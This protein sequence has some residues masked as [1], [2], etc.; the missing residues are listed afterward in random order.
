M[1][2]FASLI[3][4]ITCLLTGMTFA[5][6]SADRIGSYEMSIDRLHGFEES[7]LGYTSSITELD[8]RVVREILRTGEDETSHKFNLYLWDLLTD[9]KDQ[10]IPL[11]MCEYIFVDYY[12]SSPD[13][14]PAL[15]GKRMY[16]IQGRL[17]PEG[18]LGN[19]LE[20][21]WGTKLYSDGITANRWSTLTI[22]VLADPTITTL[23]SRLEDT[24]HYLHQM[25]LFPL[26]SD[27]GKNDALYISDIRFMSYH[28]DNIDALSERTLGFYAEAGAQS[29]YYT[30]RAKDADTVVLPSP[31]ISKLPE[32]TTFHY[33]QDQSGAKYLPGEEYSVFLGEDVRFVPVTSYNFDFSGISD[34]Y[35]NGYD[36]G[37]FRPGDNITRAEAAKII[38]SLVNPKNTDNGKVS[39][40]DVPEDAWYYNHVA[41]LERLSA[42]EFFGDR[43]DPQKKITR[44]ELVRIIYAV[45][46]RERAAA[47]KLF[48][49][50]DVGFDND[51]FEAVM[52]ACSN[53]I[54]TG[55][56]DKTF[57][58]NNPITRAETVT[59]INRF[60][61]RVPADGAES[62]F[63]DSE[64]HWASAQI[65]AAAS[66]MADGTWTRSAGSGEF[67]LAGKSSTEYINALYESAASLSPDAVRRGID[68]V[69]EQM[70]KDILSSPNTDL[71]GIKNVYYVSP[72]GNDENNG[73]S[74]ETAWK[75]LAKVNSVN[76]G[77]KSAILF[78]RGG[79]WRGQIK[80]KSN[81]TYGAY[82]EGE[83]PV[84]SGSLKNYANASLCT[85][86]DVP[87]VYKCTDT[88]NNVG[89]I[90]F[91]HDKYAHGNY[92]GLYG[93]NRI[94]S[95]N[96]K[97]YKGLCED[98]EFFSTDRELYL[99]CEGGNP[100]RRFSSIEIGTRAD[101]IDGA[102]YNCTVDNLSIKH[103]GA[104]GVG[105]GSSKN[106]TVKNCEFSW[107]GGSLLGD[108]GTTTTQ[109]GNA[110]EIY[111]DCDGYYV[112]DNWMY[113]IY[114]TAVTHQFAMR[115][116]SEC[117]M[118]D[119]EYRGNLMEYVHWG[120]EFYISESTND[121]RVMKDYI[122][123]H[124]VLREGGYGWGSIVTDRQGIARLYSCSTLYADNSNLRCEYNVIDRCAG[125]LID[126]F[127]DSSE[128][129]DSNIYVQN[130]DKKLGILK[131]EKCGT[132]RD[133]AIRIAE[134][135]GDKNA[136]VIFL[137]SK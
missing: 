21:A 98:L 2:K 135:L 50:S 133:A 120:I 48:Y 5:A 49:L 79:Y 83:K 85:A 93:K 107:L 45:G 90:V 67:V 3:L 36:D 20:F 15:E 70:K 23:V 130:E 35:I 97:D 99:Y 121:R 16:W 134:N 104:H 43:F 52:Y 47:E 14:A 96:I 125:Y 68:T 7:T 61:G 118:K 22:P 26:E 115:D 113:Q 64:K 4:C 41:T 56:E 27:M 95:V 76:V 63:D 9:N 75:T 33:W 30:M 53:G 80:A 89:V 127:T 69:S 78:E 1:K 124:N 42:L 60:I 112:Y 74:P 84:I 105:F 92:D 38:A 28:P 17:A 103:T 77:F 57:R 128:V 110:V 34:A 129:F 6:S 40:S 137:P 82:G 114:D 37:S 39:F 81:V 109:Y 59:V 65:T 108:F 132:S 71:S 31:D 13:A 62:R 11:D 91:D 46:K 25:K 19:V 94:L 88:L 58:P 12:Y 51:C 102:P 73:K 32:N 29:P 136:I 86:T 18:A 119:I 72:N 44:G 101:V 111:G 126:V 100:G 117:T 66:A 24:R 55:Y 116:D 123:H 87:N 106:I 8:G 54:V 131:K 10:Y 122:A